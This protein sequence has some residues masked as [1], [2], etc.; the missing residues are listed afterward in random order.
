MAK[1]ASRTVLPPRK[2]GNPNVAIIIFLV[3]SLLGNIALGVFFYLGQEKIAAAEKKAKESDDKLKKQTTDSLL[4]KDYYIARLR[5]LLDPKSGV[6]EEEFKR[7]MNLRAE[8]VDAWR[9]ARPRKARTTSGSRSR[10]PGS[11]R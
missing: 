11:K 4:V 2:S 9:A 3:F 6:S 7:M 8:R 5:A 10:P 1:R